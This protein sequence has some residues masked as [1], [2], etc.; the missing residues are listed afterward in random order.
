[1]YIGK[2][3]CGKTTDMAKKAALYYK[4]GIRVYSNVKLPNVYYID[5]LDLANFRP[6][7]NSVVLLDEVGT[8]FDN[9]NYKN[10]S[11]GL[12]DFFVYSRQY[13]CT[14]FLYSQS[15]DVDKKIRDRV[16]RLYLMKRV[17]CFTISRPV[18]KVL[19]VQSNDTHDK[20]K[21]NSELVDS[22]KKGSIFSC[23]FTYIPRWAKYQNSYNPP[24]REPINYTRLLY[25]IKK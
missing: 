15:F 10:F 13:K 17:G 25:F 3:G 12:R 14:V 19:D 9:R 5:T 18:D 23:Q 4:R 16:D 24:F 1:M 22:Y 6:S 11:N 20:H 8:Y 7:E 21:V 2:K